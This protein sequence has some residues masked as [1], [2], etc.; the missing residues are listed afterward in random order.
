MKKTA[1]KSFK[2]NTLK[3]HRLRDV[4]VRFWH[5][6]DIIYG[7]LATAKRPLYPRKWT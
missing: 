4:N 5:K 1:N 3:L 7:F 6:A 2:T